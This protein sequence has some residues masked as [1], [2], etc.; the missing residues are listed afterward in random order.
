MYMVMT[1]TDKYCHISETNI[2]TG[3]LIR[4]DEYL[5]SILL[6]QCEINK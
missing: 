5:T 2:D 6:K 1:K 4:Y 3:D